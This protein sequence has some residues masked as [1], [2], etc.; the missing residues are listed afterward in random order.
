MTKPM[1]AFI[2]QG[3]GA[4]GAYQA[5]VYEQL[6][7]QDFQPDWIIGTSIGAINGAIIAG[8]RPEL[9]VAKLRAFW[10]GLTPASSWIDAWSPLAWAE[11]FN[12]FAAAMGAT[13]KNEAF[14]DTM[15]RGIT[16]FFVPRLNA[17]WDLSAPVPIEQ[18]GFYD[19]S[20]LRQTLEDYVDFDYLNDGPVRLSV[21]AVNVG[22]GEMKVF[23][24]N[25]TARLTP[26]HIMAS[27]AL[28]PAF[29]PVMIDGHAYW[30]GG[31]HSNTPL[32]VLLTE[33]A[34]RDALVFMIDLW[35]PSENLPRTMAE[36]MER[37]KSIQFAGR[38]REQLKIQAREEELQQAIRA[39]AAFLSADQMNDPAVAKLAAKG[40]DR[41]VQVVRLIMKQ[42]EGDD[43]FKD[44]DFTSITVK[45][46]WSAGKADAARALTHKSWLKPVP[47]HA[48][49]IIHELEQE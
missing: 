1:T 36:V 48:G 6:F 25:G 33:D 14:F 17:N 41:T 40:C 34:D 38:A 23:D 46:R 10:D 5:G 3:G 28:P 2:L 22:S 49:L 44:A 18:A 21:C 13:V 31:I 39:L 45:A 32:E 19:I 42:L 27:G 12:P 11:I 43:Q 16:G 7:K 47:P 4:L 37:Q 9:R 30:D 24:T 26:E 35:D 29:P 15:S 8:N 20:P